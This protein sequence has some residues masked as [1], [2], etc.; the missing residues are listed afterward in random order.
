MHDGNSFSN[1]IPIEDHQHF[2]GLAAGKNLQPAFFFKQWRKKVVL[3]DR[4][5]HWY[6]L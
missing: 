6:R 3:P 1:L 5:Q 2:G 4:L